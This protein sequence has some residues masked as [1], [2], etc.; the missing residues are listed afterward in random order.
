MSFLVK[1]ENILSYV[2]YVIIEERGNELFTLWP[3]EWEKTPKPFELSIFHRSIW[4]PAFGSKFPLDF[5][6]LEPKKHPDESRCFPGC[7]SCES[8]VFFFFFSGGQ[9]SM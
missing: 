9:F 8:A 1:N 4:I 6:F 2:C 5:P 7:E 3:G